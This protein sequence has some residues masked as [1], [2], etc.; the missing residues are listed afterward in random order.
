MHAPDF[1]NRQINNHEILSRIAAEDKSAF[2]DCIK[3]YGGLVWKIVR[4]Y[5]FNNA[6]AEDAAQE[7]FVALWKNAAR[8]DPEKSPEW[9]FVSL[10]AQRKMID[11]RR[12]T[13]Y[14]R[15]ELQLSQTIVKERVNYSYKKIQLRL[16]LQPVIDVLDQLPPIENKVIRLS[17]CA[18]NSHGEISE[19][20]GLPLGTVKSHI[21]RGL[22]KMKQMLGSSFDIKLPETNF[23]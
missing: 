4:K 9:A 10:I 21:R 19:T 6:D 11:W 1:E 5:A 13:K 3:T 20:T 14:V 17:I 22:N 8:F 12:K 16:E 23:R 18:G 7:V 2:E 15:S